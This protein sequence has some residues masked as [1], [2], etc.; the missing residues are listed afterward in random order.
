MKT[1]TIQIQGMTC[2]GCVAS[3]TRALKGVPGVKDV[4]VTLTPGRALVTFDESQTSEGVLTT[5]VQ[6]AGYDVGQS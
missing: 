2:G 6:D 4:E 3:V 1:S 5:A